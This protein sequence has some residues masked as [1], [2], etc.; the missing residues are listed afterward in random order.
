MR[1]NRWLSVVLVL[2]ATG[3]AAAALAGAPQ[4]KKGATS[5]DTKLKR[6]EYLMNAMPCIDC[7]T[8]GT[9]WGAPDMTRNYSGSEMGWAGPWGVVYARN[10][11]PDDETGLGKWTE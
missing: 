1:W 4:A 7:H 3:V 6:G 2:V 8:P 9:F 10:L 11:T 5:H